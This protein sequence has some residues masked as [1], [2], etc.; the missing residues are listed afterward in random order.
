MDVAGERR[1][2]WHEQVWDF[3]VGVDGWSR[4]LWEDRHLRI[5]IELQETFR[6]WMDKVQMHGRRLA[7]LSSWLAQPPFAAIGAS[8]DRGARP[9]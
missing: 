8:V 2:K 3:L 1:W 5:V 6:F 9:G 4:R 7:A